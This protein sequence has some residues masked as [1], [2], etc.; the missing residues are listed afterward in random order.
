MNT[1]TTIS[2]LPL[3]WATILGDHQTWVVDKN[4]KQPIRNATIHLDQKVVYTDDNG[5][6]SVSE[7]VKTVVVERSGYHTF[8]FQVQNRALADTVY[9]APLEQMLSEV[10]IKANP[11][12]TLLSSIGRKTTA[13]N[14]LS[15]GRRVAIWFA[16]PDSTKQHELRSITISLR[17]QFTDGRIRV[18]LHGPGQQGELL[19]PRL[20]AEDLWVQPNTPMR[21]GKPKVTINLSSYHT[22]M[23]EKG[24]FLVLE[25]ATGKESE[26]YLRIADDPKRTNKRGETVVRRYIEVMD[27]QASESKFIDVNLY[28]HIITS[29]AGYTSQT[30]TQISP[31]FPFKRNGVQSFR[32]ND[33]EAFNIAAELEV[34]SW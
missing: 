34:I 8:Q 19:G 28:P 21:K 1:F 18:T 23:P 17:E 11:T 29:P 25:G 14:L 24:V 22:M 31:K 12:I 15:P 32:G 13:P 26:K 10:K 30:W 9:L 7:D 20:L 27:E 16:T 3:V 4:T 6:F 5:R 2:W 33:V